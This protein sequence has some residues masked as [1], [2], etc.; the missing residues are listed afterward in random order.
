MIKEKKQKPAKTITTRRVISYFRKMTMTRK[1]PFILAT[2]GIII[3]SLSSLILPIYYTKIVDVVQTS[4]INR[5]L[6]VP[7]LMG[8]L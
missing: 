2:I 4:T 1:L 3:A 7:I 6:L 8:I 5:Q